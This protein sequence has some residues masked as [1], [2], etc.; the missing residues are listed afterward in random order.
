MRN[1]SILVLILMTSVVLSA[2]ATSTKATPVPSSTYILA[3]ISTKTPLSTNT[4]LPSATPVMTFTPTPPSVGDTIIRPADNMITVYIPA[5]EFEMGTDEVYLVYSGPAHIVY[6]DAF[7]MDQTEVTNDMFQ[8]FV[9]DTEYQTGAEQSGNNFF[10]FSI[11]KWSHKDGVDWMHPHGEG[12]DLAGLGD[13]PVVYVSRNDAVAYCSWAG[14][15]LPTEAEW[16]KAGRGGLKGKKY[17]W[18]DEPTGCEPNATSEKRIPCYNLAPVKTFEPNGY[19]LYNMA[20]NV[21]EWNNDLS[22]QEY[23]SNSSYAN[24]QGIEEGGNWSLRGGSFDRTI[25]AHY[26]ANRH[27]VSDQTVSWDDVGFRCARSATP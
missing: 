1:K 18:G 19:G 3:D 20:G 7:W 27:F 16:E 26:V 12:S 2:C 5:G 10:D 9:Q 17:P 11:I 4:P 24:P 21:T 15:R 22:N 25:A 13:Y 23:Y 6:L 8:A 14:A